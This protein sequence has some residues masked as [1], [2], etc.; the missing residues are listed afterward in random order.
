MSSFKPAAHGYFE[1]ICAPSLLSI[2]TN[3]KK[4]KREI[5]LLS[6]HHY[7]LQRCLF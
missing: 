2:W 1:K 7:T 3:L 4:K 5:H 6:L